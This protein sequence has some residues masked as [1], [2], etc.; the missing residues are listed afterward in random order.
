MNNLLITI[1]VTV[2]GYLA[3]GAVFLCLFDILTKRIRSKL[4]VATAETQQRLME[5]GNPVGSDMARTLLI[6]TM[7]LFWPF[8]LLGALTDKKEINK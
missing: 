5:S 1:L 3:A 4:E 8:V 2:I 7:W 6:V